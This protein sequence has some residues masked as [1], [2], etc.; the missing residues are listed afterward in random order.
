MGEVQGGVEEGS[1]AAWCSLA[2]R[3]LR[4]LGAGGQGKRGASRLGGPISRSHRSI[5]RSVC[6]WPIIGRSAG[7]DRPPGR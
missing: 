4:G 2:V 5:V 1:G 3:R 6:E 7:S